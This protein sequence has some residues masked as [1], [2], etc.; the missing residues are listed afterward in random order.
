[1]SI[2]RG[3]KGRCSQSRLSRCSLTGSLHQE[4]TEPGPLKH[5]TAV[6]TPQHFVKTLTTSSK[7][8]NSQRHSTIHT[9]QPSS[10]PPKVFK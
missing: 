2:L 5:H 8:I 4:N 7:N 3:T 10:T 1:M 6:S 9:C